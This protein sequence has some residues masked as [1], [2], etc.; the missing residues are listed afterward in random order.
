[1][2]TDT[3]AADPGSGSVAVGTTGNQV[4]VYRLVDRALAAAP[5][6]ARFAW[7]ARARPAYALAFVPGGS[8]S[9]PRPKRG[10]TSCAWWVEAS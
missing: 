7:S 3:L 9:S 1:M 8:G 4:V 5:E 10:S 6:L 2:A